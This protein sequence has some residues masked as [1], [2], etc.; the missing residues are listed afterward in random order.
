VWDGRTRNSE[1]GFPC[2]G[3]DTGKDRCAEAGLSC[4]ASRKGA[5]VRRLCGRR[6]G[7]AGGFLDEASEVEEDGKGIADE[8]G[9]GGIVYA[10]V[11]RAL[12]A[13]AGLGGIAGFSVGLSADTNWGCNKRRLAA[14]IF[15]VSANWLREGLSSWR[16]G[17]ST[18]SMAERIGVAGTSTFFFMAACADYAARPG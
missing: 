18:T 9:L 16:K 2:R 12:E 5:G 11:R 14:G 13:E 3:K 8:G 15:R 6:E 10:E 17:L 7:G 1:G 4:C